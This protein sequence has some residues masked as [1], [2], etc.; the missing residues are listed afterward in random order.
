M[1]QQ[2]QQL[3]VGGVGMAQQQQQLP[4][5]GVGMAPVE[6]FPLLPLAGIGAGLQVPRDSIHRAAVVSV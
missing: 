6:G 3:P 4:V 5:G 2:Q 1:S